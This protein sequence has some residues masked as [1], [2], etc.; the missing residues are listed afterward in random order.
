MRDRVLIGCGMLVFLALASYPLWHAVYAATGTAR[1]QV[2]LP[3][4]EKRCVAPLAYMRASHMQLLAS[5]R[6]DA[7]RNQR[8]TYTAYDGRTYRVS[9]SQTCLG[10]CHGGKKE[11][12][13][14]CH[15]YSAVSGPYCWDCHV[16]AGEHSVASA[17][18]AAAGGRF[19]P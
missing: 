16:D 7:I 4:Q 17:S 5:W 6:E 15:T 2:K 8:L 14:K 1:P 11:F 19:A 12:C 13:D 10:Q 9:L 18:A 3:E